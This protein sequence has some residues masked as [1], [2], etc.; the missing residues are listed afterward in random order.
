MRN[1]FAEIQFDFTKERM[2]NLL[3]VNLL[4][5]CV[6]ADLI[7]MREKPLKPYALAERMLSNNIDKNEK[8][9]YSKIK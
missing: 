9:K 3:S 2:I 5:L 4:V 1:S 6:A 7:A 8:I